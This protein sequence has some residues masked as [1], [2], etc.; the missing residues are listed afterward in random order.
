MGPLIR[1]LENCSQ[2][3]GQ[4]TLLSQGSTREESA[5][6]PTQGVAKIHFHVFVELWLLG[7]FHLDDA[8]ISQVLKS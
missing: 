7:N 5:F 6:K 1:A 4:A 3:V 8:L 2:G